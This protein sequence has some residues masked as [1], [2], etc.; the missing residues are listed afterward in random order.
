MATTA[1]G[2]MFVGLAV[3]ILAPPGLPVWQGVIA[4]VSLILA[5]NFYSYPKND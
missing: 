1:I 3:A 2:A 5:L 4:V